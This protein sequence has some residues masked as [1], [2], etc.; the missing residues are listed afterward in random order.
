M[1]GSEH[2]QRCGSSRDCSI[3]QTFTGLPPM[4]TQYQVAGLNVLE[5]CSPETQKAAEL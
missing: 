2:S 4:L 1:S 3:A 5:H